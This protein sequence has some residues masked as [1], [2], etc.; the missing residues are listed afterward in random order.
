MDVKIGRG[1]TDIPASK[2]RVDKALWPARMMTGEAARYAVST[3]VT[4]FVTPGPSVVATT[5]G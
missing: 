1:S 3:L 4:V 5:P 2:S